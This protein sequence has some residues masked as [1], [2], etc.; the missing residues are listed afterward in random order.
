[1]KEKICINCGFYDEGRCRKGILK[2][3][4]PTDTCE[5]CSVSRYAAIM[6]RFDSLPE[7]AQWMI[8]R[9]AICFLGTFAAT[10]GIGAMVSLLFLAVGIFTLDPLAFLFLFT[11]PLCVF[12]TWGCVKGIHRLWEGE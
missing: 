3:C 5:Q 8:T 4:E 9:C 12:L 1:M 7:W 2:W 11:T 6:N 10:F